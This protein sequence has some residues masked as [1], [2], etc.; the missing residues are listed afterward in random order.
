MVTSLDITRTVIHYRT[1]LDEIRLRVH[2][3]D[4]LL[5]NAGWTEARCAVRAGAAARELTAARAALVAVWAAPSGD[6]FQAMSEPLPAGLAAAERLLAALGT[7]L[8]Q[9]GT[10]LRQAQTRID[11]RRQA[12]AD[13]SAAVQSL[14]GPFDALLQLVRQEGE[15][16]VSEAE[17]VA[18][19]FD[20]AL[21]QFIV[22]TTPL[23]REVA[24]AAAITP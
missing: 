24:A 7:G 16:A 11:N 2:G 12:F 22:T 9:L 15:Q 21:A 18:R 10:A 20:Q 6:A 17:E 1:Q 13:W 5:E 19:W 8:V 4:T 23:T 14:S 3:D